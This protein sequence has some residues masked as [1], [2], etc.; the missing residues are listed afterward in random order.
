MLRLR[1]QE[2]QEKL[3]RTGGPVVGEAWERDRIS[4]VNIPIITQMYTGEILGGQDCCES[5]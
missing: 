2:Y 3:E 5:T 4:K 1:H